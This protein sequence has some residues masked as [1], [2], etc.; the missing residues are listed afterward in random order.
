M[1]SI[2]LSRKAV[3]KIYETA[4]TLK[5]KYMKLTHFIRIHAFLKKKKT[6][7]Y[8]IMTDFFL[9]D[10]QVSFTHLQLC[11]RTYTPV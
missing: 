9:V 5:R 10:Q 2:F 1:I 7:R 8:M 11:Q 6:Y 4:Q 3:Y